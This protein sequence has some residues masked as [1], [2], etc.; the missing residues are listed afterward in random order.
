MISKFSQ[1]YTASQYTGM[2]P[3]RIILALYD[4]ALT[5]IERARIAIADKK[6]AAR[7]EAIGKAMRIV[8]ELQCSLNKDAGELA[9]RLD[10]LYTYVIRGL[11][12]ANLS[13]DDAVLVEMAGL[14]AQLR[15]GWS[16]MLEE[17]A[18]GEEPVR[19]VANGGMRVANGGYI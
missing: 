13:A 16:E 10:S 8:D 12:Q 9:E 5:A 15:D 7:G 14:I 1:A 6:I 2:S 4:G 3:G 17:Q 18:R 19:Q 11:I